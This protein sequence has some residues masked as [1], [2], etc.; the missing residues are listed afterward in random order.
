MTITTE[1]NTIDYIADGAITDY[2][3]NFPIFLE[4]WVRVYFDGVLQLDTLYTVDLLTQTVTFLSPPANGVALTLIREVPQ[5]QEIDYIEGDSFPADT[6][7]SALDKLTML[8]QQVQEELD[9]TPTV[10]PGAPAADY[11][12]PPY[13]PG[14]AIMWDPNTQALANSTENFNDIV[15]LATEQAGNAAGSASDSLNSAA[16]AANASSTSAGFAADA[17]AS[18][19]AAASVSAAMALALGG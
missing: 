13:D 11:N 12:Y 16:D 2:G 4:S 10:P 5:T 17:A 19:A 9:R 15:T 3:Y 18:A 1:T 6:H 8:V 14:K 7:E